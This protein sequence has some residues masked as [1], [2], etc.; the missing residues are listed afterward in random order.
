MPPVEDTISMKDHTAKVAELQLTLKDVESKLTLKDEQIAKLETEVAALKDA[1]TARLKDSNSKR[2]DAA[3]EQYK[4]V[5]KL[6]DLDK[7]AM[8]YLIEA[9]P[10]TFEKLYPVVSAQ[11]QILTARVSVERTKQSLPDGVSRPDIKT[12]VAKYQ[13]EGK[14]YD[15]AFT[16][17]MRD[18]EPAP[19]RI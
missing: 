10:D 18:V 7:E 2:V 11:R 6:T 17:A 19:A 12:L 1:E 5:K 4:D 8:S 9:K 3:F 15:E 13:G 16:L 14:S